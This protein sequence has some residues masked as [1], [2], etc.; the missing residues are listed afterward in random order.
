MPTH[1]SHEPLPPVTSSRLPVWARVADAATLAAFLLWFWLYHTGG[2]RFTLMGVRI[3]LRS[4]ARVL[5]VAV[6]ILVV[7]HLLVRRQPFLSWAVMRA[8]EP[9]PAEPFPR[10]SAPQP[11]RWWQ[12]AWVVLAL[13]LGAWAVMTWPQV[14]GMSR[15]VFDQ[16]DPLM[17][18]WQ[19]SWVAHQLAQAPLHLY[20]A[21]IFYPERSVLAYTDAMI[22]PSLAAAPVL[23]LGVHPLLV[24]NVLMAAGMVLSGVAMF[25]LVRR[26][27]AC[28]P[29]AVFAA[30]A[31]AF[32]P[33]RF[34]HYA[35]LEL[36]FTWGVPLALWALHRVL[37][38]GHWRDGVLVGLAV[39]LQAACS[40][41]YGV[42]L[43]LYLAAVGAVL[44]LGSPQRRASA[45][46]LVGGVLVAGALALVVALPHVTSRQTVGERSM[47]DVRVYS[48]TPL[49]YL[50]PDPNNR[51]YSA[52]LGRFGRH[53]KR[54][55]PGFLLAALAL[56]GLRPLRSVPRVA[57]LTGALLAFDASLGANGLV[58]PLLFEYLP[59]IRGFR[60]PARFGLLTAA[61]LVVL[62]GYGVSRIMAQV[63]TRAARLA[64]ATIL[65]AT[66]LFECRSFPLPLFDVPHT[67]AQV[68]EWLAVQ[69]PTVIAEL[70]VDDEA[71]FWYTYQSRLHWHPL[72]NGQ[73]GFF[74][75][76]Y[77]EFQRHASRFPDAESVAY[78]KSRGAKLVVLHR[79]RYRDGDWSDLE[80]RLAANGH[81]LRPVA[82]FSDDGVRVV[83]LR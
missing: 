61:S 8:M 81:L 41:Y 71:D 28:W 17:K 22:A 1:D 26:L 40:M 47:I 20:D 80:G 13:L 67:P 36:Q 23:W 18:G 32:L 49:S 52:L 3:S 53:E 24:F 16:G 14:T 48:A 79:E 7:R 57:Y 31:F 35:H 12:S 76:W 83:E 77:N 69:S 2:A 59:P 10:P 78:L 82:F 15:L 34:N 74:P 11:A 63:Q 39:G 68:Y 70:P 72:L 56:V 30:L 51:A 6:L 50:A 19:L 33:Y 55:F 66:L 5:A 54:L 44:W 21:N 73:S 9:W 25:A 43:G 64:V 38:T 75:P 60:V 62:A 42:F 45:W 46:A 29:A 65:S 27:T 4:H 37:Q 58:F